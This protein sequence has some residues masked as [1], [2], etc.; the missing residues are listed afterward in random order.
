VTSAD[1]VTWQSIGRQA[2]FTAPGSFVTATTA[3]RP[4]YLVVGGQVSGSRVFAGLWWS[5][6]L[7]NWIREGNGGL[8]GRLTPSAAYAVAATT[9]T[10]VAVGTHG[11]NGMIWTSPDGRRWA[12][13]ELA[14]PAHASS[15]VL[16]V[17]AASGNQVVAGGY[18][19]TRDGDIPIVAFSADGGWHWHQVVLRT[20]T[21]L[22][23]VTALTATGS[24]YLAAGES[25]KAATQHAVTW[26]SP[27]G[28]G[29]SAAVLSGSGQGRITTL[30]L[31]GR[32]VTATVQQGAQTTVTTFRAP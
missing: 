8:D 4:G 1:G 25:G 26:D 29:W 2:A 7:K 9:T 15:A 17:A 6:D 3:G 20:H 11:G 31:D 24:G 10:F 12:A 28:A 30:S 22:G 19:V 14:L 16:N 5:A 21:G 32:A 23:A 18:A 27:D 13:R